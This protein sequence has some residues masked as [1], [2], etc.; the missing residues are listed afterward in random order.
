MSSNIIKAAITIAA[1]TLVTE[2]VKEVVE[3]LIIMKEWVAQTIVPQWKEGAET[4][5]W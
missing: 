2:M 1:T 4:G 3:I 5:V